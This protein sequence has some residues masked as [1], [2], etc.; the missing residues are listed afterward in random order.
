MP[1]TSSGAGDWTS[2]VG[3]LT[4]SDDVIINHDVDLDGIV[5]MNG[6][7]TINA[8][9]TLDTTGSNHNLTVSGV[10]NLNGTLTGNASAITLN[11]DFNVNTGSTF[12]TSGI[13]TLGGG[14]TYAMVVSNGI[15]SLQQTGTL[16]FNNTSRSDMFADG[17]KAQYN[18]VT[19]NA[20]FTHT[21]E[22][23]LGGDGTQSHIG[24]DL[25]L[26]GSWNTKVGSDS[27]NL[28]VD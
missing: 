8:T 2:V 11:D 15:T 22:T 7:L 18:N 28:R 26:N 3:S 27:F 20:S 19:V 24:G 12:T 13:T 6:S 9:K 21:Q 5:N 4:I 1:T 17:T 16:V 23:H 14:G 10:T 25:L